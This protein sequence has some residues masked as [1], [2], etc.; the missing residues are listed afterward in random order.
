MGLSRSNICM[1]PQH[2]DMEEIT[3][4]VFDGLAKRNMRE[5]ERVETEMS[6]YNMCTKGNNTSINSFLWLHVYLFHSSQE[7]TWKCFYTLYIFYLAGLLDYQVKSWYY[8]TRQV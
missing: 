4:Q 2:S 3:T 1:R 7:S 5:V 8:Q 6:I